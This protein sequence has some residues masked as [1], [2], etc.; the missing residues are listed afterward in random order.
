[1]VT[2]GQRVR[3]GCTLPSSG[4]QADPAAL[5]A[6]AQTA[7]DLGFDSVWVD[8]HVIVPETVRSAYPYRPDGRFATAPDQPFLEP[9]ASLAYLAGVTRRVRLGIS[10]LVLPYRHPLLTAKMIATI[11]TLSNGRVEL[12]VGVGWMWEEFA[13]LGQPRSIYDHRGVATEEQLRILKAVWTQDI[14]A[15]DGEFYPFERVGTRPHPVQKPHPPVWVGGH[16]RAALRRA[17]RYGDGWLPFSAQPP[18]DLSAETVARDLAF[19]QAEAHR[20]GRDPASL[21]VCLSTDVTVTEVG[22]GSRAP[23]TGSPESIAADFARHRAAGVNQ[24]I[25]TL[26]GV[27]PAEFERRLREFADDVRPSIPVSES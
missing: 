4:P 11:D 21:R 2:A 25:V 23:F 12:G 10:V 7:E 20:L 1:M 22:S 3:I 14:A 16:S 15:G 26:G 19:I 8:D 9:V 24:F 13:A 5:G 6:L 18:L 27:G 17:A